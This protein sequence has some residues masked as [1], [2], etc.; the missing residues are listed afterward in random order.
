MVRRSRRAEW[1]SQ[2]TSDIADFVRTLVKEMDYVP[3]VSRI[4]LVF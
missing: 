1:G 2:T 3:I 4:K